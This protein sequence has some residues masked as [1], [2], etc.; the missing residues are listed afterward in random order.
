M[1]AILSRG[2]GALKKIDW[3]L[4]APMIFLIV[5]G[6]VMQYSI[7]I[8]QEAPD[9]S[10]FN[11]QLS[12]VVIGLIVFAIFSVVDPRI[13]KT[14]PF[15]YLAIGAALLIGVLIFGTTYKGTTGWFIIADFSFQPV[16]LVKLIFILFIASYF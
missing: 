7:G 11:H 8:N 5:A 13:I 3:W 10:Q 1:K 4:I 9:L 16:E 12:F 14:H 2:A 15:I 6:L